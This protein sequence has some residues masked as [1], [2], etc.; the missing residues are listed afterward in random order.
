MTKKITSIILQNKLIIFLVLIAAILRFFYLSPWLEDWDSIQLALGLHHYSIVAH[1]PHPPG[2]P[3]YI[4]LGRLFYIFTQND[5][6]ALTS[7]SA[8]L[9]SLSVI[10]F[11]L[12]TKK[13]FDKKTAICSA[14][15]F[16]VTPVHW[17]FSE[18]V[19]TDVPGLFFLLT[20]GYF[21]YCSKGSPKKIFLSSLFAGLILGVRFNEIPVVISL[22]T[23]VAFTY[24]NIK[25]YFISLA[26]FLIGVAIWVIP[27]IF[28]TGP[29]GFISSF[30]SL[31]DY[32]VKHDVL[33][34]GSLP[35]IT[36]LKTKLVQLIYL[37]DLSY[38]KAFLILSLFSITWTALKPK[39]REE[40]KIQFLLTWI[41]S[42]LFILLFVYNLEIQRHVLPLLPPLI[43]LTILML[44]QLVKNRVIFGLIYLLLWAGIFSQGLQQVVRLK[45]EI[46]PTIQPVSYVKQN[47]SPYDTIILA[48]YIYPQFQYY[49]PEFKSYYSDKITSLDIN[50]SQKVIIDY[51]SLKNKITGS[52]KFKVTEIKEFSGD[53]EIFPKISQTT[54]YILEYEE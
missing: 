38:T 45:R 2:Y 35:L 28:I 24:G 50:P 13:M 29:S 36:L 30:S 33:L 18:R 54:L 16:I 37:F 26:A 17:V 12:L 41:I 47:F 46:P 51:P 8:V 1:Q 27:L 21:I 14:L 52:E 34:G 10:P 15:I 7:L 43:I 20:F 44:V 23:L 11:Y 3:L 6:R 40:F 22:I 25:Y 49:P 5:T 9:G 32:V 19:F 48:S 4:I 39:L 42:Y 31:A 53:R